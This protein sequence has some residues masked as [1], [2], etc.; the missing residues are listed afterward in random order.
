M[1]LFDYSCI[2]DMILTWET[3]WHGRNLK[4]WYLDRT[5]DSY[6]NFIDQESS[7]KLLSQTSWKCYRCDLRFTEQNIA[8]LHKSISEHPIQQIKGI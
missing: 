7:Y 3:N 6:V 5:D 1:S 2:C 4:N 8:N